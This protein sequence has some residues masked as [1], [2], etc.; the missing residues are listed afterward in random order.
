MAVIRI[1]K[2]LLTKGTVHHM[3][4]TKYKYRDD[5]Q[6]SAPSNNKLIPKERQIFARNLQAARKAAR[7]TQGEMGKLAG[8]AQPFISEIENGKTTV[9]L[10]N[11]ANLAAAV[12]Q[13]LYKLLT[14]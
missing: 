14:P 10:D 4:P 5:N 2:P 6:I 12:G 13:P 7:I 11:A 8:M 1:K 9:S 3:P